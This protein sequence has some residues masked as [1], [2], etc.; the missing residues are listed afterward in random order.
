MF[1]HNLHYHYISLRNIEDLIYSIDFCI[2]SAIY[3]DI[4]RYGFLDTKSALFYIK[5]MSFGVIYQLIDFLN[6][7][8]NA[9]YYG[10][11]TK[12]YSVLKDLKYSRQELFTTLKTIH[13][14]KDLNREQCA[15]K[16]SIAPNTLDK[17]CQ[18]FVKLLYGEDTLEEKGI[19]NTQKILEEI[20]FSII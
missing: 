4:Y 7:K 1:L 10:R 2:F 17:H 12:I 11:L 20:N 15:K 13:E 14:N 5:S 6:F 9:Q 16:I 18:A 3:K 19:N 8:A